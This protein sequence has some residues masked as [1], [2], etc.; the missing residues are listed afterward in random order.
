M[1]HTTFMHHSP[2]DN[3]TLSTKWHLHIM[4]HTTFMHHS[5]HN[6]H[7]LHTTW[8]LHILLHTT[9]IYYARHDFHTLCWT[10][11]MKAVVCT[12]MTSIPSCPSLKLFSNLLIFSSQSTQHHHHTANPM[13][14]Q[15]SCAVSLHTQSHWTLFKNNIDPKPPVFEMRT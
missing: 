4:P 8:H 3:H 6:I 10:V 7:T 9:I 2:H 1:P 5:P 11:V 12:T 14:H 13:V 15:L